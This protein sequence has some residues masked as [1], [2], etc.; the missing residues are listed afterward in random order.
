MILPRYFSGLGITGFISCLQPARAVRYVTRAFGWGRIGGHEEAR[1]SQGSNCQSGFLGRCGAGLWR[2]RRSAY[3]AAIERAGKAA[4]AGIKLSPD[5]V[6]PLGRRCPN[7]KLGVPLCAGLFLFLA[8]PGAAGASDSLVPVPIILHLDGI[9]RSFECVDTELCPARLVERVNIINTTPNV[10]RAFLGFHQ[11]RFD[12]AEVGLS[13][14]RNI[15]F[16]S[17]TYYDAMRRSLIR[18]AAFGA[19]WIFVDTTTNP[20]IKVISG[21]LASI[22]N[23]ERNIEKAVRPIHGGSHLNGDIRPQLALATLLPLSE[24]TNGVNG[25]Q[26]GEQGFQETQKFKAVG[27]LLGVLIGLGIWGLDILRGK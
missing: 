24:L 14:Y 4:A 7:G 6:L 26:A 23:V 21:G 25:Y 20:I 17:R 3:W 16:Q 8:V 12:N 5:S 22:F 1:P 2:C 27:L 13:R 19:Q 10:E 9:A 15:L 11:S 18:R